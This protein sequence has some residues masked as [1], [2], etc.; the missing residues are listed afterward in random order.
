MKTRDDFRPGDVLLFRHTG[1]LPK[2]IRFFMKLYSK[3]KNVEQDIYY[4]HVAVIVNLWGE[5]WVA[6]AVEKGV[7]V[8]DSLDRYMDK[9]SVKHLTWVK[10]LSKEEQEDFS[11]VA[12]SYA[13]KVTRYDFLNFWDQA[14]YI[15]TGEWKGKTGKDSKERVY[16]SKFAAICMDEVRGSFNGVTW[17]KNPLDIEL[18][19]DLKEK[20]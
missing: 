13:M 5:L 16:C 1:F 18:C 14:R 3:R 8:E 11:K 7:Q 6:D 9:S 15:L 4:N 17:D 20:L 2:V 19:K 12:I 10:P